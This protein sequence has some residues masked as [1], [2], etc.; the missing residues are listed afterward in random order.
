[1][2]MKPGR[3]PLA[4]RT[5]CRPLGTLHRMALTYAR[6]HRPPRRVGAFLHHNRCRYAVADR[7]LSSRRRAPTAGARRQ[8]P[9]PE[10]PARRR[11]AGSRTLRGMTGADQPAG[12]PSPPVARSDEPARP[13]LLFR[14]RSAART[15]VVFSIYA[16]V[17][18]LWLAL[19]AET[20]YQHQWASFAGYSALAFILV[21]P[22]GVL[23]WP[24]R[25][26]KGR[27]P[28]APPPS[29]G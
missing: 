20:A 2:W 17:M 3:H 16:L 15:L 25:A 18:L 6:V 21:L 11:G 19:A 24:G 1:M 4:V 27:K 28:P 8:L 22:T 5:I 13:R 12:A 26:L 14:R 23:K 7:A 10:V 9:L 29:S